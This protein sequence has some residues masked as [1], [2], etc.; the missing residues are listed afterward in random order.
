M[1]RCLPLIAVAWCAVSAAPQAA[2]EVA[3]IKKG[4]EPERT[5]M[6]CLVP[7]T[8]GERFTVQGSRVD[9]RYMSIEKLIVTAYGIKPYQL[10]GPDWMRSERFDIQAKIPEGVS[11][12][13]IPEMLQALL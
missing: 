9:I 7:C 8:P 1:L 12:D 6:I 5:P 13:R 10:I 3:S 4:V 2:F 11:K